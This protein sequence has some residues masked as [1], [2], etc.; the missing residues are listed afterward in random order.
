MGSW[1]SPCP[2]LKYTERKHLEENFY[3]F[4]F[5]L[6]QDQVEKLTKKDL[7]LK[8][9]NRLEEAGGYDVFA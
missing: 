1:Q 4:D 7:R 2:I 8:V 6:P 3:I 5:K 9:C